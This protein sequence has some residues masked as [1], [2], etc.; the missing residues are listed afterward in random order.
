M[1]T[2]LRITLIL[3]VALATACATSR[4]AA[5]KEDTTKQNVERQLDQRNYRINVGYM[6]PHRGIGRA[7][8]G[9]YSL[10]VNGADIDSRLPYYGVAQSVPYGG[11]KVLSFKDQIDE[12]SDEGWVKGK[13]TITLSTDN[14]EDTLKYTL[15]IYDNGQAVIRV[16]GNNRDEIAYRGVLNDI[17][18]P[19]E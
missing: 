18:A 9:P 13:R 14:G 15:T 16:K 17:S 8:S 10:S 1:K 4:Q 7:V 5:E 2:L 12:Y 19:E 11:G 6:I 3:S